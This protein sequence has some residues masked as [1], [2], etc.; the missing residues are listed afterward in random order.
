[1]LVLTPRGWHYLWLGALGPLGVA[2]A[3]RPLSLL[4][5]A[6]L[7]APGPFAPWAVAALTWTV[8]LFAPARSSGATAA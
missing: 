2:W 6:G 7:L 3:S 1:L 4:G 5:L 8:W